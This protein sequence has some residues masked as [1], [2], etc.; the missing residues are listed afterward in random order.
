MNWPDKAKYCVHV[1]EWGDS[2]VVAE[3]VAQLF[4][5]TLKLLTGERLRKSG[6]HNWWYF[7]AGSWWAKAHDRSFDCQERWAGVGL[8]L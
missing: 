7:D 6:A 8:P 4:R 3:E 5:P 1:F 2:Q